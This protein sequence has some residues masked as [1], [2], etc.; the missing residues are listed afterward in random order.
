MVGQQDSKTA[1]REAEDDV[2]GHE[3]APL[4]P[5]CADDQDSKFN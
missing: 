5:G 1:I 2:E 3:E 4:S